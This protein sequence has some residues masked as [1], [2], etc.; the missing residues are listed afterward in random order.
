MNG[1]II[2]S[3]NVIVAISVMRVSF[4]VLWDKER[5]EY[6]DPDKSEATWYAILIGLLWC[7]VLPAMGIWWLTTRSTPSERREKKAAEEEKTRQRLKELAKQYDDMHV[8]GLCLCSTPPHLHPLQPH[9]LG[10]LTSDVDLRLDGGGI[11]PKTGEPFHWD[12]DTMRARAKECTC[13]HYHDEDYQLVCQCKHK[14]VNGA[15]VPEYGNRYPVFSRSPHERLWP[16]AE[17]EAERARTLSNWIRKHPDHPSNAEELDN[18]IA[19]H[20]KAAYEEE[21]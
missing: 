18:L 6:E 8:D 2:F 11:N 9:P 15:I 14:H 12:G 20:L 19:E 21:E 16:E 3:L 1:W 4:V 7:V 5:R 13:R 10:I 17:A